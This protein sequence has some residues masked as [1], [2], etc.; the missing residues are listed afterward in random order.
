MSKIFNQNLNAKPKRSAFDLSHERKLTCSMGELVPVLLQEVV[1]G[2]KFSIDTQ[3]MIRFAPMVAPTMHRINA[4]IHF[5]YVPNR[6]IW[7]GWEKFITGESQSTLPLAKLGNVVKSSIADHLG[8]PVGEHGNTEE[9]N[10]LPHWAY[11]QI[12]NDYYMDENLDGEYDYKS[13]SD[14]ELCYKR[15]TPRAWEKDYFTSALPWAQKG[16][17]VTM[18]ANI[19][20]KPSTAIFPSAVQPGSSHDLQAT[21]TNGG[22]EA[23]I[24][25]LG[26]GQATIENI[27]G[28][29]VSVEE[30]RR[31]TRLQRWLE[32][33]ARSGSRYVEH[34]LAHWGVK[35]SDAR[36]Q[37]AEYIGGGKSPVVVSEVLNTTGT[38]DLP[39]G[40]MAGHGINVGRTNTAYKFCEEHGYILGIMSVLPEPTYQDGLPRLFSRKLNLDFYFPEFAQL[41]EQ[42]VLNK[43][44]F[45]S[46]DSTTDN[47]TFGYQSRYAEY[48]YNQSTVHGE[49]KDTL[50]FWHLGRK[51]QTLPALNSEFIE[52]KPSTRIFAV[53]DDP[54][55]L[56]IQLY[57]KITAVRPIPFFNDPK[58]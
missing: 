34:L 35:S 50:D 11:F 36:L 7:D 25:A 53:T 8:L 31:A 37:R 5:F 27:D 42:P 55:H 20:Y 19:S 33:N 12:M 51:F 13:M 43:E 46:G 39:Q 3:S 21:G 57:H 29:S 10:K 6:I 16:N 26:L 47:E 54:N 49:F 2:D 30:L 45:V 1:P 41:G 24:T 48:K 28:V 58:L 4:Y 44:I 22:T 14:A 18:D 23:N 56:Y 9:F 38:T 32:R 15:C 40:N 52:C 17:P